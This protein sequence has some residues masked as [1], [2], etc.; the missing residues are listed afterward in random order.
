MK[1]FY[2]LPFF[3]WP[4]PHVLAI[5]YPSLVGGSFTNILPTSREPMWHLMG[6]SEYSPPPGTACPPA[7][8]E[9]SE[10]CRAPL[11]PPPKALINCLRAMYRATR[12]DRG[13]IL[14]DTICIRLL[15]LKSLQYIWEVSSTLR[16]QFECEVRPFLSGNHFYLLISIFWGEFLMPR[17][18]K[19]ETTSLR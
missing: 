10:K 13:V 18:C 17:Q 11:H 19:V 15:I 12:T 1:G 9:V 16:K 14:M 7:L 6:R 2:I 3:N 8:A 5:Y 4:Q